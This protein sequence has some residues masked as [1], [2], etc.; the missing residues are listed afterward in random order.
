MSLFLWAVGF[1]FLAGAIGRLVLLARTGEVA[2]GI[3]VAL[4]VT[5]LIWTIILLVKG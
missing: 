4:N 5:L 1:F 3:G 2:Y